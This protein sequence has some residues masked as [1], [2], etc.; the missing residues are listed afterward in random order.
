[1]LTTGCNRWKE[2]IDVVVE[3]DAVRVTDDSK[4]RTLADLW[5]HKYHGDWDFAVEDGMFVH[6]DGGSAVVL[7]GRS[8]EGDCVRQEPVRADS[9]SLPKE[10]GRPWFG[11][12]ARRSVDGPLVKVPG[13]LG[14][15]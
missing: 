8:Y 3:G 4:L 5:R 9:I 1:M 7:G 13:Q 15:R 2:G 12:A 10:L 11:V 6:E 14:G